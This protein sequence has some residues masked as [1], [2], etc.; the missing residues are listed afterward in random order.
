MAA[1]GKQKKEGRI[2]RHLRVAGEVR[3]EPRTALTLIRG[4]LVRLWA[5][6]GGGLY[7]LGVV[8]S[9]LILEAR[10][11]A[12]DLAD[13]AGVAD[14][15]V[16]EIVEF[17]FR[18]GYMSFVNGLLA[19]LWPLYV[20]ERLELWGLVLLAAG[21]AVFEY[22]LRP[23]VESRVPE[24]VEAREARAAQKQAKRDRKAAKKAARAARRSGGR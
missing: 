7:G 11:I 4:W 9:F 3:R 2:A 22:G 1:Q 18:L 17:V 8:V 24:L 23:L 20:L 6:R 10:M 19:L 15:L 12:G 16:G 21:Y 13:S 14:F 5:A